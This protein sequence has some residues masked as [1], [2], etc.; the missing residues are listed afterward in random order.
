MAQKESKT[1]MWCMKA[2]EADRTMMDRIKARYNLNSRAAAVRYALNEVQRN[3]SPP[4]VR[5]G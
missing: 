5:K 4:P 3:T 2:T 1:K